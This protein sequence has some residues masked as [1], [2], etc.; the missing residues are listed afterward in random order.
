MINA[1][2]EFYQMQTNPSAEQEKVNKLNEKI[3]GGKIT[4]EEIASEMKEFLDLKD[5]SEI[6]KGS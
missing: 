1:I 2:D 4:E 3:K 6:I 5:E